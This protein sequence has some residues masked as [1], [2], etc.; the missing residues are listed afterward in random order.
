MSKNNYLKKWILKEISK[1]LFFRTLF[2]NYILEKNS[3]IILKNIVT[4]PWNGDRDN[5]IKLLKGFI[6]FQGETVNYKNSIWKKNLGSSI[7]RGQLHCFEW[8]RDLKALGTNEARI[9]LRKSL[10]EWIRIFGNWSE[11]EW[12]GDIVGKRICSLL[13][14]LSFF[15]LSADEKFQKKVLRNIIKQVNHLIKT[16]IRD[17][18]GYDRIF[19]IKGIILA[20]LSFKS[21]EKSIFFGLK[22]LDREIEK[23][24]LSDGCHYSKA[25]S[26]HFEFLKNIIDIRH[27]LAEGKIKISKD[28]NELIL[29]MSSIVKFFRTGNGSLATFNDTHFIENEEINAV[30]LRAN[31]K[32]PIPRTLTTSGFQRISEKK[33]KFYNGLWATSY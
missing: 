14:N 19:A 32:L 4:D 33:N 13:G 26:K 25:P 5:G 16:K 7:L 1:P 21:H 10:D 30:Q 17:V 18:E 8:V 22:L 15:C 28:I 2:Y 3:S 6:T 9:F 24:I 11:F 12:R 29:K 31:S 27:Y 23:Q 20:S